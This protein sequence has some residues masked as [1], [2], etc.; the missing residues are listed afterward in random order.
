ML[1][2]DMGF[3]G[4]GVS[5]EVEG[6]RDKGIFLMRRRRYWSERMKKNYRLS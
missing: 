3:K 2:F 4:E 5:R 6:M 1:G